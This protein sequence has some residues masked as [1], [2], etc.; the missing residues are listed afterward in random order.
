MNLEAKKEILLT[1]LL[2]QTKFSSKRQIL[3]EIYE[4][5]SFNRFIED[6]STKLW[7]GA[8]NESVASPKD[9]IKVQKIDC[10][11]IVSVLQTSGQSSKQT[12]NDLMKRSFV[13][14]MSIDEVV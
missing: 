3:E 1:S 8:G 11:K 7:G 12:L 14:K 4:Y 13:A 10:T 9:E 6:L 5:Y 2:V